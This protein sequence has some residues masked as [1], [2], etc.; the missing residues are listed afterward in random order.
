[1]NTNK[2]TA[3][4]VHIAFT[5]RDSQNNL[6]MH[7][8]MKKK[9][10][11]SIIVKCMQVLHANPCAYHHHVITNSFNTITRSVM[12]GDDSPKI[13][14]LVSPASHVVVTVL[15]RIKCEWEATQIQSIEL[16]QGCRKQLMVLKLNDFTSMLGLFS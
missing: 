6:N 12:H 16:V 2:N 11:K 7:M 14:E 8:N 1:M 5:L 15:E 9:Q 13:K 3:H 4:K 10:S